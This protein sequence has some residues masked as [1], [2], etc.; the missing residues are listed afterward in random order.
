MNLEALY[1]PFGA[2]AIAAMAGVWLT[3][4]LDAADRDRKE[5]EAAE[6]AERVARETVERT[7]RHDRETEWKAVIQANTVAMTSMVHVA[8]AMQT[9]MR[10]LLGTRDAVGGMSAS[11]R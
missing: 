2:I 10:A 7:D 4:R 8:E 6:R 5:R 3:R 9:E 1:G 11:L